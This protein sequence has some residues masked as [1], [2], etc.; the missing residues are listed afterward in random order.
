[1]HNP[2]RNTDTMHIF[3]QKSIKFISRSTGFILASLPQD[4]QTA[5]KLR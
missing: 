3:W 2:G 5:R 1:M 4:F